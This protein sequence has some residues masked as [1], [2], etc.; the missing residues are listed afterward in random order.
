MTSKDVEDLKSELAEAYSPATANQYLKLLKSAYNRAIRLGTLTHN[1]VTAVRLYRENNA[2]NRCLTPEEELRLLEALPDRVRPLVIVALHTGMRRGELRALKW[3]DVDFATNSL[4]I[5]R[6]KAGDERWVALNSTARE[7]LLAAKREQKVLSNYVFCSP[8][9][10]FLHNFE[11]YWRPALREARIPDLRFHDC[12]HTF[13]SRLPMAGV[14]LYTVQK[15]GGWKTQG[16]VQRYARLSPD[17]MRVVVERDHCRALLA[18]KLALP[19][20]TELL[21]RINPRNDWWAEQGS[22]LRPRPCKG[23]ALPAELSAR[24]SIVADLPGLVNHCAAIVPGIVPVTEVTVDRVL[25]RA[26]GS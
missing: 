8:Q 13:A 15:A 12:R 6:D 21:C 19:S 3:E 9:G 23:R 1:P 17:H 16:M 26:I 5:R 20:L 25:K 2:R 7:G 10:K 11:R 24:G 14:D 4:R 18:Q 22:N